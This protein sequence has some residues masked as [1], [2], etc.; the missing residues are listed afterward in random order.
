MW[1]LGTLLSS[2]PGDKNFRASSSKPCSVMELP[3]SISMMCVASFSET[4]YLLEGLHEVAAVV[5]NFSDDVSVADVEFII[6]GI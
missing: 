1:C 3:V 6:D 4:V 2:D 5:R